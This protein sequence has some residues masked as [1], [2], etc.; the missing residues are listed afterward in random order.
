[1]SGAARQFALDKWRTQRV[2]VEVWVEKEAL[3]GVVARTADGLDCAW[4]SCRGYVSQSELWVAA[5]RHL[6]YLAD[7]QRVVVVHLGDHDPSG[8]DMT[9]DIRDRLLGFVVQDWRTDYLAGDEDPDDV[10]DAMRTYLD[11]YD[12]PIT[13]NRIALNMDQIEAYNPPPNPAKITD[14]RARGYIERYGHDSWE[15]DALDPAT[16]NTLIEDAIRDELDGDAYDELSA[17]EERQREVLTAA[18]R[19]WTEVAEF[20]AAND[21]GA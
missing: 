10:L 4:F 11:T 14:S 1:V 20:L 18:S 16:L 7:G 13:V 6:R 21:A 9:R 19:R 12:D 3:A 15:L 8:V 5:R 2:R 17:E